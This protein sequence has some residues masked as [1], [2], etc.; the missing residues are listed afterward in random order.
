MESWTLRAPF[1]FLQPSS[2]KL[3]PVL[4]LAAGVSLLLPGEWDG[5]LNISPWIRMTSIASRREMT[6]SF[7]RR[8]ELPVFPGFSEFFADNRIRAVR[9]AELRIDSQSGRL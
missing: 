8:R 6:L 4:S 9:F 5:P 1:V 7:K 3:P 2:E